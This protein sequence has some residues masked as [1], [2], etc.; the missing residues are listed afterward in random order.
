MN[1]KVKIG[2]ASLCLMLAV[3]FCIA[4]L[5]PLFAGGGT[6]N[7]SGVTTIRVWTDNASD[8]VVRE[9]Q[10]A[11]YNDGEGKQKGIRIEYTVYGANYHEV[12]RSAVLNDTAPEIFRSTGEDI[13][14]FQAMGK[15]MALEDLP[16]G[17]EMIAQYAPGDLLVNSQI[18]NGK[19]YSLPYSMTTFKL[20]INKTMFDAAGITP[21]R[22]PKTWAD[23]RAIAR[24]LTSPAAGKYGYITGLQSPW[25]MRSYLTMPNAQNIGL[26]AFNNETLQFEFSKHRTAIEAVYGMVTDGSVFPGFEGLDADMIR[27]R[28]AD[29][30]IGMIMGA[31]FDCGVYSTQ[32]PAKCDW[33]PID[34][35][36][37]TAGA[38]PYRAFVDASNLLTIGLAAAK[39]ADKAM[40]VF[41]FFYSDENLAELYVAGLYVPFRQQ[42]LA[43]ARSEPTAKGFREFAS[44]PN[45][46]ISPSSPENR[47]QVEGLAYRETIARI[48]SRGYNDS[49]AQVLADLDRRYNAAV[50]RLPSN[51][52]EEFRATVDFRRR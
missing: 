21:D 11:R 15:L 12:I 33:L 48:L 18:F 1:R 7:T 16:G 46:A 25:V 8:R 23:V 32:F 47:I 27:A 45:P 14:Q 22:Y 4:S 17:R 43:L 38:A 34:P 20:I 5:S 52:Q 40:E 37:E 41:K 50:A 13:T 29:G 39:V 24:Q 26:T 19:T 35:P 42:A 51:V 36:T 10:I 2:R 9:R 30:N 31:S 44:V 28:F 3:C 6:A 49:V